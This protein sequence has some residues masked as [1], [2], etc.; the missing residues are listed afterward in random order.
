MP[1][2]RRKAMTATVAAATTAMAVSISHSGYR[3]AAPEPPWACP[4]ALFAHSAEAAVA[5]GAAPSPSTRRALEA[6][7]DGGSVIDVG[8]GGGA[9]SLPLCPPGRRV[10]GVDQNPRML[11]R[12]AALAEQQ[13]VGHAEVEGLWPDVAPQVGPVDV[14]VC[15]HVLYNVADL[16]PFAA[17][18]TAHARHRVVV[19]ITG[20]HPQARLNPLWLR[21]HGN[22]RPTRPTADDAVA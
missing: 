12:F 16:V 3:A 21:F 10:T 20:D 22:V 14:V 1:R 15:H 18:L 11:E 7:P 17:A 5:P 2:M 19:E 6:L 4:P 8:V 13:G 9:A